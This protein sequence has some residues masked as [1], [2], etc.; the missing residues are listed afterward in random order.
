[1]TG[2]PTRICCTCKQ[3]LPLDSFY[4]DRARPDGIDLCCKRC[5]S[6]SAARYRKKN[7]AS[8]A[9]G[10]KEYARKNA[11]K[12]KTAKKKWL[13]DPRTKELTRQWRKKNAARILERQRAWRA[14]N[15]HKQSIYENNRRLKKIAS[16]IITLAEVQDLYQKQKGKCAVCFV[17][18]ESKYHIDHVIPI[19]AGGPNLIENAQVLC[20]PCNF[21]KHAKDPIQFR[22]ERGMLL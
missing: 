5:R 4:R 13:A 21:S 11:D 20:P 12:I 14:R 18:L 19:S 2:A 16:G 1:M 7:A 9:R 10:K 17:R 8:V 22:Q 15:P 6:I 3:A